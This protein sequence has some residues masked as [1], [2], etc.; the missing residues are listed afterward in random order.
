MLMA[1]D[2]GEK[3]TGRP[4]YIQETSRNHEKERKTKDSWVEAVLGWCCTQCMLVLGVRGIWCML[5][6]CVN[7]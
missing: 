1:V 5:V 2:A 7:S 3:Y 6:L 4:S